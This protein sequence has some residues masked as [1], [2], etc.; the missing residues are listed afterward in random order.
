MN[1][2]DI[3]ASVREFVRSYAQAHPVETRWETPLVAAADADDPLFP[4]LKTIVSPDH[5]LPSDVLPGAKTV[6]SWFVPFAEEIVESNIPG[7]SS[8]RQWDCAYIETNAMLA[9]LAGHICD[10]LR[11]SGFRAAVPPTAYDHS[12]LR[13]QWSQR[14]AAFIAGLGTFGANN[15]LITEKGCCGRLGSVVTD[16]P[17]PATPRPEREFCLFRADGSCGKCMERCPNRA[18]TVRSGGVEFDRF[19]CHEQIERCIVKLPIGVAD[20]C[21]KCLCGLPCSLRNPTA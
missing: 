6:V 16:L 19:R 12:L 1:R 11:A 20:A 21:G 9:A 15:M 17:L 2:N 7:E 13:S 5:L 10:R 3:E 8:S 18:Y 4:R 14:S